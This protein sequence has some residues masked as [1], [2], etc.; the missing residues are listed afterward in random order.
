[1]SGQPCGQDGAGYFSHTPC[2]FQSIAF[3]TPGCL[4]L[5]LSLLFL[6]A[7]TLR[8]V[9]GHPGWPWVGFGALIGFGFAEQPGGPMPWR[10]F[11][12]GWIWYRLYRSGARWLRP[13][14]VPALAVILSFHRGSFGTMR[15]FTWLF[16]S[17]V[18][19]GMVLSLGN[20]QDSS[21]GSLWPSSLDNE[22]EWRPVPATRRD[23]L[24][25]RR[26]GNRHWH[27]SIRIDPAVY[28]ADNAASGL[29]VDG[30][31]ELQPPLSAQEPAD[32][33]NIILCTSLHR[34]RRL[35]GLGG[36]FDRSSRSRCL[37]ASVS[38][39]SCDLLLDAPGSLLSA[40]LLIRSTSFSRPT[41]AA[42]SRS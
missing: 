13:A 12:G 40:A 41:L 27:L 9:L 34:T 30:I 18:S 26:N 23:R 42:H 20:N 36:H 38:I 11:L 22:N 17:A 10:R 8:I 16:R 6:F 24:H 1:M 4:L 37:Y 19:M 39:L 5:F 2:I 28:G 35:T 32:P 15:H 25:V 31:L 7:C 29:S 21:L 33:P 14:A 3:G